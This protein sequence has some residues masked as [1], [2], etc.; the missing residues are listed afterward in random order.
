MILSFLI[1]PYFHI[2]KKGSNTFNDFLS[3]FIGENAKYHSFCNLNFTYRITLFFSFFFTKGVHFTN[4]FQY[5]KL[6]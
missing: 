2:T 4:Y 1:V 6:S 3:I 5:V